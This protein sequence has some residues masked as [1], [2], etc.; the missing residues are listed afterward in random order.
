MV[1]DHTLTFVHLSSHPLRF[2]LLV[3][4]AASEKE[5]GVLITSYFKTPWNL[6]NCL[7]IPE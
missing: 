7:T 4:T 3:A 6:L 1:G 2:K 5:G